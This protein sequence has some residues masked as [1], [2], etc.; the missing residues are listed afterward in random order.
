MFPIDRPLNNRSPWSRALFAVAP[1]LVLI[2]FLV[3]AQPSPASS[4]TIYKNALD[5][6]TKRSNVLQFGGDAR[7]RRSSSKTAIRTE[8]GQKTRECSY[9]VP[10]A[11]KSLELTA[12]GRLSKS[13]PKSIRSRTF[14]GLSLRHASGGSRYQLVVFPASTRSQI[15]KVEAN[16]KVTVLASNKLGRKRVKPLGK[17]NK[18]TF[19][20]YNGTKGKPASNARLFARVNGKRVL[21]ANDPKGNELN[22]TAATFSVGSDNFAR[23]ASASFAKL[24]VRMPDPFG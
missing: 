24:I 18:M 6:G 12:T 22:G 8:L 19:G 23:G 14:L 15:R 2:A 1:L 11:G 20:A 10:V 4:L 7:C 9:R 17:P 21:V 13:T 5:T 16:G 3:V